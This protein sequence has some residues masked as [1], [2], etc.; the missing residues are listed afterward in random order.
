[1]TIRK[2]TVLSQKISDCVRAPEFFGFDNAQ[3]QVKAFQTGCDPA[4]SQVVSGL[5]PELS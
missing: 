3:F 2:N 1:M 5:F 4:V